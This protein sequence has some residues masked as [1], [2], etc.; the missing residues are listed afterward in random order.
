VVQER[1]FLENPALAPATKVYGYPI[2]WTVLSQARTH[3]TAPGPVSIG[4]AGRLHPEKGVDILVDAMLRLK[5]DASL[6]PWRITL[7]GPETVSAGGAGADYR[8]AQESKLRAALPAGVW[9]I[10]PPLYAEK[11]LAAFYGGLD[12]FCYPSLAAKGETFGVSVAEAMA[13]GAVPVVSDL[14][15][16]RDF[17][18]PRINGL[19]FN[20]EAADA[21]DQLASALAVLIRDPLLRSTLAKAA[22][23][24]VRRYDFK[25]YADALIA[26]FESLVATER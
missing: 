25:Q 14:P 10:R 1:V 15:C 23:A 20:H 8:K 22:Q 26:D 21:A 3:A 16:F 19:T 7:C 6:P 24:D 17:V 5:Q 11:A 4:F 13:A 18:R 2:D 9:S 12:I